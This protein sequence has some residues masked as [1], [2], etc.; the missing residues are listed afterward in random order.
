MNYTLK[1]LRDRVDQLIAN[2]GED[3]YCGAWIYTKEDVPVVITKEGD[4][5]FPCDEHPELSERIF[6]DIGNIDHIYTVIQ[7]CVDEVSEEQYMMLQ[8]ELVEVE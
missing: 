8:Q 3:A 7:E 2:Q 5:L 1:Q 6:N 4:E